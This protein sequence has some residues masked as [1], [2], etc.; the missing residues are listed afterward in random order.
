VQSLMVEGG[1]V[2]QQAWIDAGLVDAVQY[3]QTPV[4][5]GAGVAVAPA[6]RAWVDAPAGRQRTPFGADTLV[7]GL[8]S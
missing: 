7:D 5:L 1:P 2:L 6:L 4:R 3:V 8:W